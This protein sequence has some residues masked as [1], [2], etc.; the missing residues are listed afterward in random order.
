MQ[1]EDEDAILREVVIGK[2][3]REVAR[4]RGL[5]V[6]EV[7]RVLDLAAARRFSGEGVRRALLRETERLEILTQQLWDQA[8]RDHD[9]HAAAVCIKASERLASL[10]GMNHPLGHIVTVSSTLEPVEQASSTQRMLEAI[11]LLRSE[12]EAKAGR[13]AA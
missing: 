10:T 13:R 7:N 2:T 4:A 1:P 12:H 9:L 6:P 8:V 5:T 3:V 11:R